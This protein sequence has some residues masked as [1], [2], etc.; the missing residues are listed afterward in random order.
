MEPIAHIM[1]SAELVILIT[2][3][4]TMIGLTLL[5]KYTR[6]GKAMRATQQDM[7]M[8][9]LTGINVDRGISVAFIIGSV[10]SASS[11]LL[12]RLVAVAA[13]RPDTPAVSDGVLFDLI[14]D[15]NLLAPVTYQRELVGVVG[16]GVV[17]GVV[18]PAIADLAPEGGVGGDVGARGQLPLAVAHPAPHAVLDLDGAVVAVGHPGEVE[19][20]QAGALDQPQSSNPRGVVGVVVHGLAAHT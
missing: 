17:V 19:R 20:L 3:A 7:V 12:R 1:G 2:S 9:R 8:A 4:I 16:V 14:P 15:L 6:I 18:E 5:I 11:A 10:L 13:A